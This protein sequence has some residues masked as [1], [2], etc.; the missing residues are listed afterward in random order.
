MSRP[1]TN[2]LTIGVVLHFSPTIIYRNNK[3][4]KTNKLETR[5]KTF[6]LKTNSYI[7][8]I[9]QKRPSPCRPQPVRSLYL[10]FKIIYTNGFK[11]TECH[12]NHTKKQAQLECMTLNG[13]SGLTGCGRTTVLSP[14]IYRSIQ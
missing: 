12:C 13:K 3:T 11:I 14:F 10:S 8:M 5:A 2:Q 9:Y 4:E 1:S 6:Y 7:G